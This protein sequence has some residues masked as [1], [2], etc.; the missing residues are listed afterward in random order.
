FVGS[1]AAPSTITLPAT[2]SFQLS[3]AALAGPI[4]V[5]DVMVN[6]AGQTDTVVINP[7]AG[8]NNPVTLNGASTYTGNTT[9]GGGAVGGGPVLLGVST[10]GNPGAITSGPF[11]TG[12]VIMN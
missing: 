5:N 1:P 4:V 10:V 2:S 12:T 6:A 11:G 7:N 3:F 9:T 8:N